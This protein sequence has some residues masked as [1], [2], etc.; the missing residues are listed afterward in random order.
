M[1]A[2]AAVQRFHRGGTS[3]LEAEVNPNWALETPTAVP[4]AI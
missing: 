3:P 2:F 1:I 4:A